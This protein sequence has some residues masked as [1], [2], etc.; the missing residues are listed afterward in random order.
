MGPR[1]RATAGPKESIERAAVLAEGDHVRFRDESQARFKV[2]ARSKR[3][4]ILTKPFNAQHTV[5]YTVID[6]EQGR[7]GPTDSWG[8]GFERPEE[9]AEALA[10]LDAG[11]AALSERYSISLVVADVKPDTS[12][13]GSE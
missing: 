2:R 1:P 3:Y 13:G 11:E 6:L 9:I 5:I 8:T 12:K 4:V 10:K 7:R